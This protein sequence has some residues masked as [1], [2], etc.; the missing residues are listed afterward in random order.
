M[1]HVSFIWG[2]LSQGTGLRLSP[3]ARIFWSTSLLVTGPTTWSL[4][5]VSLSLSQ[6]LSESTSQPQLGLATH[7]DDKDVLNIGLG[8][9]SLS[10]DE[11]DALSSGPL[12]IGWPGQNILILLVPSCNWEIGGGPFHR[13]RNLCGSHDFSFPLNRQLSKTKYYTSGPRAAILG[14]FID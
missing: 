10:K 9:H 3:T 13:L 12:C 6:S 7:H 1:K 14:Q 4:L 8:M 11:Q 5:R 2:S